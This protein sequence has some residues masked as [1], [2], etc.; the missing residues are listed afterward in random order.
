MKKLIFATANKGKAREAAEILGEGISIVLPS[1]MGIEE[2]AD[3]TGQ[4]FRENSALKARFIYDRLQLDGSEANIPVLADDSGLEVDALGGEPGIYTARYAGGD[5]NFRDNM[6]KLLRK[7]EE[8]GALREE[9]RKARF[10]CSV[11]LIDAKGQ[12]SFHEGSLEGHIAFRR[13]GTGGFGYDPVFF[14][15]EKAKT[16]GQLTAEEKS[17]I[18]DDSELEALLALG[19]SPEEVHSCKGRTLAE[20]PESWKNLI[21]HRY[22][23]LKDIRL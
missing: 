23:A 4:S 19:I 14:V 2:E 1:E 20:I 11:T 21:S 15:P 7:L 18:S 3:E 16:F 22:K 10:R 8:A 17:A 12:E 13:S 6:D 5:K 9:D